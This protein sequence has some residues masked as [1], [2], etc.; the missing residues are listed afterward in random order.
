MTEFPLR[1]FYLATYGGKASGHFALEGTVVV[2]F[3]I[4]NI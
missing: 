3:I 1:P 2:K 4:L